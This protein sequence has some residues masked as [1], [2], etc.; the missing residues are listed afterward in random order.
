[1]IKMLTIILILLIG[2]SGYILGALISGCSKKERAV[3]E[4]AELDV[5]KER[6]EQ[7]VYDRFDFEL[8]HSVNEIIGEG[9]VRAERT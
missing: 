9:D 2:I 6:I 5:Y 3:P 4:K 8:G 7:L 1:M